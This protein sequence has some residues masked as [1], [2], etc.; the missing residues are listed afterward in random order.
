VAHSR[1]TARVPVYPRR[2]RRG[3][4]VA[5]VTLSWGG[6]HEYPSVYEAG[7]A[8]LEG[9]G[10]RVREL[11]TA[12]RS[13]AAL[14]ADPHGR[15]ADLNRAFADP[16]VS[17]IVASIGGDDSARILPYL[18]ADV[19]RRHPK[20]LMGYSDTT[21]ELFVANQLGLVTFHGPAVM[22][23]LAQAGRFRALRAHIG[24]IL[25]EPEPTYE[26]APYTFWV[27]GYGDWGG[28]DPTGVADLRRHDG[29]HWLTDAPAGRGRLVGGSLETLEL[30]KGSRWWPSDDWWQGRILFVETSEE[31]PTVEQVRSWLFN[32][33]VQGVFDRLAGL[34]VGRARGYDDEEKRRLDEAISSVVIDDFGAGRLPILTNADFGHTDPQ[35]ILPLGVMAELDPGARTFRLVEPAVY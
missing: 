1:E 11:A 9:L 23:G 5:V 21:V 27:D 20:V 14:R 22:A 6:P 28:P 3:D 31:A 25:F 34:I 30:L 7:L 12:R 29:W 8:T 15:A 24:A 17:A 26:Y 4:T 35:W 18:D 10:L 33:G 19:I 32:Y 13:T 2:L 16:S